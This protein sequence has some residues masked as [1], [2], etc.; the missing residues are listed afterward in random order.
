MG[1]R[2]GPELAPPSPRERRK[3]RR[4]LEFRHTF[5]LNPSV[6]L[7][8]RL[9]RAHGHGVDPAG[10]GTGVPLA[11]LELRDLKFRSRVERASV[12]LT[13]FQRL[14]AGRTSAGLYLFDRRVGAYVAARFTSNLRAR[15]RQMLRRFEFGPVLRVLPAR[16]SLR[17][18][19]SVQRRIE[20][21]EAFLAT[22]GIEVGATDIDVARN[23][24]GI[25]LKRGGAS[26]RR[27]ML[28]RYEHAVEFD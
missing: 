22:R 27:L 20:D 18:L 2:R 1:Y 24:V 14:C 26:G 28:R 4:S 9:L 15:R 19:T 5:R 11:A 25:E 3:I 23:R 6:L 17:D 16:F 7:I 10:G 21:D 12:R 8:R 13:R